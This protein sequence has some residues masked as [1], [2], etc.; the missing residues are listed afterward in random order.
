MELCGGISFCPSRTATSKK[1]FVWFWL[2]NCPRLL[3]IC[4]DL[5][6]WWICIVVGDEGFVIRVRARFIGSRDS[7]R[8]WELCD[9]DDLRDG[10][11]ASK[12]TI[13]MKHC[14]NMNG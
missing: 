4:V 6:L 5:L 2:M 11:Q 7:R 14:I 13:V 9:V 1:F 8:T 3:A 12:G 10:A